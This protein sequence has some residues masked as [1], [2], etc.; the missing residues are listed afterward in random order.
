MSQNSSVNQSRFSRLRS[1]TGAALTTNL[2]YV[3]C[4]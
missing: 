3:V 4:D 1:V 2:L